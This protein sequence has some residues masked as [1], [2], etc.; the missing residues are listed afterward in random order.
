VQLSGAV[1]CTAATSAKFTPKLT[2]AGSGSETLT[3]KIPLSGCTG[4]GTT[5][6]GVT[7]SSGSL[8]ATTTATFASSCGAA[9]SGA[10]LPAASG[11][12]AWHGSGGP[13]APSTVTVSGLSVIYN[14]G[15]DTLTAYVGST[16]V[17]S[18]SFSGQH[19]T[20]GAESAKKDAYKTTAS[21]ENHGIGSLK[22]GATG[23]TASVGA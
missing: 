21:C 4:A 11:T 19:V 20:F 17:S 14:A 18:G 13:I 3:I 12:I 5:S 6:G 9:L 7:M 1:T 16:S 23:G 2:N 22:F 8:V 10:S 15:A